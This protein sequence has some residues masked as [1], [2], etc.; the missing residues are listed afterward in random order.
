M[1]SRPPPPAS[2]SAQNHRENATCEHRRSHHLDLHDQQALREMY[3]AEAYRLLHGGPI[4]Y[5]DPTFPPH[6]VDE[7]LSPEDQ[8]HQRGE[9]AVYLPADRSPYLQ[10]RVVV[11]QRA[12]TSAAYH[13]DYHGPTKHRIPRH[14]LPKT[15]QL[16]RMPVAFPATHAPH[17][18]D[19]MAFIEYDQLRL[20]AYVAER[21]KDYIPT[22]YESHWNRVCQV[23]REIAAFVRR[24]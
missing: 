21:L 7:T 4:T 23:L 1:P 9:V 14:L 22:P 3:R 8:H 17:D 12:P 11:E 24:I 5:E 16:D 2:L 18:R 13:S 15:A 10:A 20:D 6:D 19:S